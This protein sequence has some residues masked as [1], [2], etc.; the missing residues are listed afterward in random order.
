MRSRMRLF[1]TNMLALFLV[2]SASNFLRAGAETALESAPQEARLIPLRIVGSNVRNSQGEYLGRV[3]EIGVNPHTGQIDFALLDVGYPANAPRL[4][5]I[6]W[7]VL[8]HVW[9]QSQ[10]GGLPGA[11]QTFNLNM[12]RA[13]IEQAPW[14]GRNAWPSPAEAQGIAAYF[15]EAQGAGPRNTEVSTV[16]S[17]VAPFTPVPPGATNPIFNTNVFLSQTNFLPN[18]TNVFPGARVPFNPDVPNTFPAPGRTNFITPVNSG[19]PAGNNGNASPAPP[20]ADP[21]PAVPNPPTVVPGGPA[22]P[23]PVRRVPLTPVPRG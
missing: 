22:P 23:P 2:G 13:K 15:R 1:R 17:N 3:E 14:V 10:A 8:A 12:S 16:A 9:D 18:P 6:P 19:T 7:N 21:A 5:P 4:T 11:V 20:A